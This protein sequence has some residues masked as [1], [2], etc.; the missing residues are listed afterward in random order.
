VTAFSG[1]L[2]HELYAFGVRVI[3]IQTG[4]IETRYFDKIPDATLAPNSIYTPMLKF[5]TE[6]SSGNIIS[7]PIQLAPV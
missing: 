5:L 7:P 1:C 6:M 4:H 3:D 2:R